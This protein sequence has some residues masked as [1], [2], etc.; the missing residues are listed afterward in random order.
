M[1]QHIRG[2][3]SSDARC[4]R[5]HMES[6][7]LDCVHSTV[8]NWG[9]IE[10]GYIS[11]AC[12]TTGKFFY[13]RG[14]DVNILMVNMV[15]IVTSMLFCGN[16]SH[17]YAILQQWKTTL[18]TKLAADP[19][20]IQPGLVANGHTRSAAATNNRSNDAL[21]KLS[22]REKADS[23]KNRHHRQTQKCFSQN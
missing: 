8:Q 17:V 6:S 3:Q 18:L 21:T 22:G 9:T 15:Y 1:G 5:V 20:S 23:R 16:V 11:K 13:C 7:R 19:A 4:S 14:R 10:E 2:N 12:S